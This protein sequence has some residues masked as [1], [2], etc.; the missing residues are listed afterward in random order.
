MA[1]LT[2]R[3]LESTL[4]GQHETGVPLDG[5]LALFRA[6]A[7]PEEAIRSAVAELVRRRDERLSNV[8]KR[9]AD[10]LDRM[11]V[12]LLARLDTSFQACVLR[13][14]ARAREHT[15]TP[16]APGAVE[17]QIAAVPAELEV[18]VRH[19]LPNGTRHLFSLLVEG[20]R[21]ATR[22]RLPWRLPSRASAPPARRRVRVL[23]PPGLSLEDLLAWT[24]SR[25]PG[26]PFQGQ[27]VGLAFEHL[28][29]AVLGEIE[30]AVGFV[31][32]LRF[33]DETGA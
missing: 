19:V 9:K 13:P 25:E 14:L 32:D 20:N 3:L 22:L 10:E 29:E 1:E 28:R 11:L 31:R 26:N 6:Q 17:Y 2:E 7:V 15:G 21:R 16:S 33:E 23:D 5:C 30:R 24:S 27:V 12:Q 18:R 4:L 8:L